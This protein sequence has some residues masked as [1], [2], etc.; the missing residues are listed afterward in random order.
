MARPRGGFLLRPPV[1]YDRVD[2]GVMVIGSSSFGL[3]VVPQDLERISAP[4][5][6][7]AGAGVDHEAAGGGGVGFNASHQ[8]AGAA[9][10][11]PDGGDGG[12]SNGGGG[13]DASNGRATDG[14]SR[15]DGA[16]DGRADGR[17]D[18]ADNGGV[19]DAPRA[20]L[21]D[22][23]TEAAA[24]EESEDASAGG[25]TASPGSPPA[26]TPIAATASP[27]RRRLLHVALAEEANTS[28]PKLATPRPSRAASRVSA[29]HRLPVDEDTLF[30]VFLRQLRAA[31]DVTARMAGAQPVACT[32][33]HGAQ[34]LI[35]VEAFDP[36]ATW[37]Q[38]KDGILLA[39][40]SCAG[41]LRLGRS[42]LR[43]LPMEFAQ[44]KAALGRSCSCRHATALLRAYDE[45]GHGVGAVNLPDLFLACPALRGPHPEEDDGGLVGTITY[46]V[47]N[48]GKRKNIPIYAVFYNNA[49]ATVVVRP[50]SNKFRLATCCQMPCQSRPWGCIHAKAV[51]KVTRADASSAVPQVELER[52]DALQFGPNGVL[53]EEEPANVPPPPAAPP[54]RK[55]LPAVAPAP[56]HKRRARNMFPCASE[57]AMCDSYSAALDALRDNKEDHVLVP[58]HA[59]E[60][61]LECG[62]ERNGKTLAAWSALLYTIRGRL[63]INIGIW[64]CDNG[65]IVH[66]DGAHDGLFATSPETV[67]VR[68]FLDAVLGICV[69]GRS[70]MAAAAEYLTS[71]LRNTGAYKEGEHG[72]ARQLLSDACGEFSETLVIPDTTFT[73]GDCGS[74][75]ADGGRFECVLMDGQILAVLQE[76]ILPMLR[77]GMDA[78]RVNMA[79]TYACA[80]RNATVRAV[81]RHRVR[82]GAEDAVALTIEE[83]RKYRAFMWEPFSERPAPPPAPTETSRGLRT[84]ADAESALHWAAF[85]LFSTFFEVPNIES[86]ILSAAARRAGAT[87]DETAVGSDEDSLV[88]LVSGDDVSSSNYSSEEIH[89]SA[90]ESGDSRE[91][92]GD[93]AVGGVDDS[94]AD[95]TTTASAAPNAPAAGAAGAVAPDGPTAV[96]QGLQDLALNAS[97]PCGSGASTESPP[98]TPPPLGDGAEFLLSTPAGAEDDDEL[99]EFESV[100]ARVDKTPCLWAVPLSSV[101]PLSEQPGVEQL[102]VVEDPADPASRLT[103]AAMKAVNSVFKRR[104]TGDLLPIVKIGAIPLYKENFSNLLRGSWLDD[105]DMN[106]YVVLLQ[107]RHNKSLERNPTAP[108]NYFFNTF[109]YK[110]LWHL[111]EYTYHMVRRWTKK[112]DIFSMDTIF[113]PVIHANSHWVLV[114][115]RVGDD[116]GTIALFDSLGGQLGRIAFTIRQWLV[117][118]ANDKGKPLRSW[119]IE[120]PNCRHQENSDDCGV[121]TLAHMDL[122]ARGRSHKTMTKSTAYYRCRIAAELLAGCVGGDG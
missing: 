54:P 8:D 55:P 45:L 100:F 52:E 73:C 62:Q 103:Q 3:H 31:V 88:D 68:V 12:A 57:V 43:G 120:Y 121:F 116:E 46:L 79:V 51:N 20:D 70:T 25:A 114:V 53:N 91:S 36:I 110:Q 30:E 113:I 85:K 15:G 74:K 76:H 63:Q 64:T 65:H 41:V 34:V 72:Q 4:P 115:V 40:C 39:L 69:I 75:E 89:M 22:W 90:D 112:V 10:G 14:S 59:E 38:Y 29:A 93:S 2:N 71:L 104:R 9:G 58:V 94:T 18:G 27:A 106:A 118:E 97:A 101:Q 11:V 23:A 78:P 35:T 66:Y 48:S 6:Q 87:A 119:M 82:S 28:A 61:C 5:T 80:V 111:G 81:M 83:A 98:S 95:P 109:L 21:G 107:R 37:T 26:P 13:E 67:Y 108:K 16:A 32:C 50:T 60:S 77:P 105:E 117:D 96:E 7:V 49:W 122:M 33:V 17:A 92:S 42:S 99:P 56:R 102:I 24:A 1:I 84:P 86:V 19:G 44:M 47:M